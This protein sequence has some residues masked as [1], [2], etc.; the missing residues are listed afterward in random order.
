[1]QFSM[2]N[3]VQGFTLI[4]VL[5]A[6]SII[7]VAI[8]AVFAAIPSALDGADS[9]E[10]KINGAKVA[11][12]VAFDVKQVIEEH[13]TPFY[14]GKKVRLESAAFEVPMQTG[15][16]FKHMVFGVTSTGR[17]KPEDKTPNAM[18][19]DVRVEVLPKKGFNNKNKNYHV[20]A[21]AQWPASKKREE[22]ATYEGKA[23]YFLLVSPIVR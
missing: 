6:V 15:K 20:R 23:E 10:M 5:V 16:P 19:F 11:Q 4:E 1:M 21:V 2:R 3:K 12:M 9:T 22:D 13:K 8:L 18:D 17:L 7:S 14:E